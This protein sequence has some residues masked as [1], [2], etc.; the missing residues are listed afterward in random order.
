MSVWAILVAAGAGSR[1][2]GDLP[3]AF[4][5]LRGRPM[6]AYALRALADAKVDGV[7][8][9]IPAGCDG[10]SLVEHAPG[11]TVLATPGG[12]TR[13][14]SVRAGLTLVPEN[15]RAIV[16]HDAARPLADPELFDR[17]LTALE[18][19]DAAV[20]AIPVADT[21]KKAEDGRVTATVPREGLWRAQTPQ[22]FRAE[23]LRAAH[24]KAGDAGVEAT[25]DAALVEREGGL[26]VLVAGDERNIK[27]TTTADL[28][29]AEALLGAVEAGR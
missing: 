6:L 18:T 19:A 20:C 12:A 3:K 16:V 23:V 14:E 21:L 27:V 29:M 10:A 2:G 11:M 26:V 13:G 28:V 24:R 7:V 17:A 9:V 4:R 5:P 22:A 15:A 25:D 8:V 1:L